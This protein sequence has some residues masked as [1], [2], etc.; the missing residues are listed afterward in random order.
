MTFAT[1]LSWVLAVGVFAVG[2]SD[3]C[4]SSRAGCRPD[5]T[6]PSSAAYWYRDTIRGLHDDGG[7]SLFRHDPR[8]RGEYT[9]AVEP[10][11][12]V[13]CGDPEVMG[14][15]ERGVRSGVI[16]IDYR[17]HHGNTTAT[18]VVVIIIVAIAIMNVIIIV[19]VVIINIIIFIV[20]MNVII[21]ITIVVVVTVVIIN[22]IIVIVI[23]VLITTA[24]TITTSTT[25]TTNH[26]H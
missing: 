24:T 11:P 6:E 4:G 2:V 23:F 12:R 8:F 3:V 18:I 25:K 9:F 1:F 17:P 5:E 15:F 26:H 20:T 10:T 19:V 7:D 21:L 14:F 22:I 16:F 13:G